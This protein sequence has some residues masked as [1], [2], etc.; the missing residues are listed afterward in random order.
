[1]ETIYNKLCFQDTHGMIAGFS[2]DLKTEMVHVW[3]AWLVH[4]MNSFSKQNSCS[5]VKD[6]DSN[7]ISID[8][9]MECLTITGKWNPQRLEQ[10]WKCISV[11]FYKQI[12]CCINHLSTQHHDHWLKASHWLMKDEFLNSASLL[13]NA[14]IYTSNCINTTCVGECSDDT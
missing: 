14:T 3:S 10:V 11:E 4:S 13:S 12:L 1:M 2:H 6:T 8:E 9:V 5:T 7:I